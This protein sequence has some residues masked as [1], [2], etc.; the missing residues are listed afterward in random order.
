[1]S[2]ES[3]PIS[4]SLSETMHTEPT[5]TKPLQAEP[6]SPTFGSPQ[7]PKEDELFI[8]TEAMY[9]LMDMGFDKEEAMIAL[10]ITKGDIIT[11]AN[12]LPMVSAYV[13]YI[14]REES[15]L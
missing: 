4:A 10:K 9:S 14:E 5:P 8:Y 13:I 7:V 6:V 15:Y 2:V 1:M 3:P 12:I 11:A